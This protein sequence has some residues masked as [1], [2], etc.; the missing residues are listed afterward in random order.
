MRNSSTGTI[1]LTVWFAVLLL[2]YIELVL[3]GPPLD[4]V[5]VLLTLTTFTPVTLVT[6]CFF[7]RPFRIGLAIVTTS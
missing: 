6:G 3:T 2:L 4:L 5:K 1:T 7:R